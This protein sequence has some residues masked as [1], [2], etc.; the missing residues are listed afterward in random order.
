MR[1]LEWKE[2]DDQEDMEDNFQLNAFHFENMDEVVKVYLDHEDYK[3]YIEGSPDASY[4]VGKFFCEM[5][6]G[7]VLRGA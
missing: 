4:D 6:Y 3:A 7:P 1:M 5:G 2:Y